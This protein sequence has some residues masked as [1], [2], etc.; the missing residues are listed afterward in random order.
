VNGY[1]HGESKDWHE[2]GQLREH[3]LYV[4]GNNVRDLIKEPVTEEDKFLMTLECGGK[5]I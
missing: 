5:W 3:S 4:N 2:N 1:L